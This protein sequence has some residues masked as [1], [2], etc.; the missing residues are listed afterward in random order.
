M[1][2]YSSLS[3]AFAEDYYR[4]HDQLGYIGAD[5]NATVAA[6]SIHLPQ[7]LFVPPAPPP[8]SYYQVS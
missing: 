8:Q 7:S 2:C 1:S 6:A 3:V 4:S 5:R